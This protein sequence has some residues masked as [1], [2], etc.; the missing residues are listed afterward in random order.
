MP[1][2]DYR[3]H[4][5]YGPRWRWFQTSTA[6]SS[7]FVSPQGPVY[8]VSRRWRG[9]GQNY[10]LAIYDPEHHA[11]YT[12]ARGGYHSTFNTHIRWFISEMGNATGNLRS[13]III[14][15]VRL[16]VSREQMT[17]MAKR[18]FTLRPYSMSIDVS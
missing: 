15:P 14:R 18:Q 17:A 16:K 7:K 4:N 11:V 6:A 10:L 5:R 3:L 12:L 8:M 2:H 9:D 1:A 13:S